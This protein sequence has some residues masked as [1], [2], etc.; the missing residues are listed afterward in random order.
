MMNILSLSTVYWWMWFSWPVYVHNLGHVMMTLLASRQ[1]KWA[2]GWC[3]SKLIMFFIIPY[4]SLLS[5]LTCLASCPSGV[6]EL[7][8]CFH[9]WLSQSTSWCCVVVSVTPLSHIYSHLCWLCA[10][11]SG[12]RIFILLLDLQVL[13][14]KD[15]T[16]PRG[17][18]N[19]SSHKTSSAGD[20]PGPCF[21]ANDYREEE[22]PLHWLCP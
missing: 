17:L 7:L 18:L 12:K 22:D 1:L 4:T 9:I 20:G 10:K 21:A 6:W 13:G 19:H 8:T 15:S 3:S 2:L 16:Q 14:L 5:V 11:F